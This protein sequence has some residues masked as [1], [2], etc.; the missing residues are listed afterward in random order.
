MVP[1]PPISADK[2]L[3]RRQARTR[4]RDFVESLDVETRA[5]LETD[6]AR[7]LAPSIER[8]R[9]IGA[10]CPLA[11]EISPLPALAAAASRGSTIAFPAFV[12]AHLPF[13]FLAGDP[14]EP[15]PFFAMQPALTANEVFPDLVL[16]PL[17]AIDRAG[18]RLGQGKGHYDR[19]LGDLKRR[20]AL[21]IGLGWAVQLID[22]M[23]SADPWDVPLDGFASP[24]GVLMWR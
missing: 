20:G 13:R 19:V 3:L 5:A 22:E 9:V 24:Q 2:V 1:S 16:V 11:D 18:T 23:I 7:H 4:R 17:V 14:V 12:A 8:S 6:L 10:Y 21:L 15:G